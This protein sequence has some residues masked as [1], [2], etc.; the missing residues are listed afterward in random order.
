MSRKH[1]VPIAAM[2]NR[3]I[4]AVTTDADRAEVVQMAK[5]FA[6]FFATQNGN[7]DR[8]RFMAACGVE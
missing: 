7:F 8:G 1:F 6:D 5:D 4:Q 3:T 2:I